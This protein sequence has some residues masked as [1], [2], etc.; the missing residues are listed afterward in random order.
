MFIDSGVT[1]NKH[2]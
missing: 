1:I 2:S